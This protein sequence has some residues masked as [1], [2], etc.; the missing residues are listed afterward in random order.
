MPERHFS[1]SKSEVDQCVCSHQGTRWSESRVSQFGLDDFCESRSSPEGCS[2]V[3]RTLIRHS[4]LVHS[5]KVPDFGRCLWAKFGL[6]SDRMFAKGQHCSDIGRVRGETGRM[7]ANIQTQTTSPHR[8]KPGQHDSKI[9]F[10]KRHASNTKSQRHPSYGA[11]ALGR[12]WRP[13]SLGP[14]LGRL[15]FGMPWASWDPDLRRR[16]TPSRP[17]PDSPGLLCESRLASGR[18]LAHDA[19]RPMRPRV[20]T[21]ALAFLPEGGRCYAFSAT[22]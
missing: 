2:D 22:S 15:G 1:L 13:G 12:Q 6:D 5:A 7:F 10:R 18:V 17:T 9:R 11:V 20:G 4:T 8:S 21:P 3:A 14:Q 19:R 16:A